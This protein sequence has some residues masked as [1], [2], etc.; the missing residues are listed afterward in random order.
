[1]RYSYHVIYG[2]IAVFDVVTLNS[3]HKNK[4]ILNTL[5]VLLV[6]I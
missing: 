2:D 6:N 4:V 5:N 3:V 1:M